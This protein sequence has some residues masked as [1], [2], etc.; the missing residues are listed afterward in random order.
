VQRVTLRTLE[1]AAVHAVVGNR[2]ADRQFD[3]PA[4]LQ[5]GLSLRTERFELA[6]V[7]Y[8]DRRHVLVHTP[9][10]QVHHGGDGLRAD[11]CSKLVACSI[12]AARMWPSYGFSGKLCASTINPF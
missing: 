6:A 1:P 10:A 2:L 12:C 5:P 11:V 4:S 3:G 7:D 8:L 9:V